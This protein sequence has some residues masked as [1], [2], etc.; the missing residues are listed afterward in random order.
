LFDIVNTVERR[1]WQVL[2]VIVGHCS[3]KH[4]RRVRLGLIEARTL[5]AIPCIFPEASEAHAA[6]VSAFLKREGHAERQ[7]HVPWPH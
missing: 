5:S 6:S 3:K 2:P 7:L 1:L 4:P